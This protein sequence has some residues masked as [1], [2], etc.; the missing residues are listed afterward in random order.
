M[1]H[2]PT[3]TPATWELPRSHSASRLETAFVLNVFAV[4]LLSYLLSVNITVGL[5]RT[6]FL[7]VAVVVGGTMLIRHLAVRLNDR[8]I[9]RLIGFYLLKLVATL[10]ILFWGWVPDLHP[11]QADSGYD[12]QRYYYQSADLLRPG[13][14]EDLLSSNNYPGVLFYYAGIFALFGHNPAAPALV[15]AF[16][17]LLAVTTLVEAAYLVM[18]PN[19][20]G[21]K[22]GLLMLLPEIVWYDALT[23]R[24]TISMMLLVC[25]TVPLGMLF[26]SRRPN[27][28]SAGRV[29]T[30]I[31][32]LLLLGFIRT[33]M[34][35]PA[36]LIITTLFM[37]FG[38]KARYRLWAVMLLMVAAA[39]CWLAAYAMTKLRAFDFSYLAA[40]RISR[41]LTAT[42]SIRWSDRSLGQLL[43][44]QTPWQEVLFAPLRMVA[45][46][47]T[48]LPSITFDWQG[49]QNREW[50]DWQNFLTTI[51]STIYIWYL[52]HLATVV[53]HSIT[54]PPRRRRLLVVGPA[55]IVL[56]TVAVGN[57][58]L[59]PRYRIM[60]VGFLWTTLCMFD[61]YNT[62]EYL[63]LRIL[64]W[65]GLVVGLALFFQIKY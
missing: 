12:P 45:Y 11:T 49:L 48:P 38:M 4:A 2:P 63:L 9:E 64:W 8:R 33:S 60:A 31:S 6:I 14:H 65:A 24:E 37:L 47:M 54:A 25:G 51:S 46:L 23:S 61:G 16:F 57:V 32:C 62:R 18:P 40:W 58:I 28:T 43:V 30:A 34:M 20:S 44:P 36:F 56:G 13:H 41:E 55:V 35:L 15:N 42:D 27:T 29:A 21:W 1:P 17:T 19:W 53:W 10:A 7:A 59:T 3:C 50:Q 5:L 26:I 39:L 52:P 22:V